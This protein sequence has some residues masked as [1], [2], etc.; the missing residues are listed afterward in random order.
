MVTREEG[1]A[2]AKQNGF[3]FYESSAKTGENVA[4]C[5][6]GLLLKVQYSSLVVI[7]LENT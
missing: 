3:L 6:E 2:F 1:I 4:M 5:F 7:S